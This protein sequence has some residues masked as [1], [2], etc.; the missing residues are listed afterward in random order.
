MSSICII[1][2]YFGKL[3]EYFKFWYRSCLRNKTIN[4]LLITDQL[5]DMVDYNIRII[6]MKID[7]LEKLAQRKLKMEGIWLKKPYKIC[8]FRP[9]FG[10]IFED[11]LEGYDFW[12][13][14]DIDQIFGRIRKFITDDILNEYEKINKNGHL[15]LYKN[16]KR[17]NTLFLKKGSIFSYLD[18]F[19]NKENYAFDEY[20]GIN[21]ISDYQ[22]IKTIYLSDFS[23]IDVIHKR[24]ICKN[25]QNYN[26]QIYSWE[27][28]KLFK[29]Y[30]IN[31][32]LFKEEKMYIHF[33]KKNPLI[34]TRSDYEKLI[35]GS[36]GISKY[37][38]ITPIAIKDNNDYKG[39]LYEKIEI[40]LYI[41]NKV[42]QFVKCNSKQKKI[43]IKQ[44]RR[45]V[46]YENISIWNKQ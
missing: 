27:D 41:I 38:N 12:G 10:V 11:F 33:Q 43:W 39:I 32:K 2:C 14:C 17:I 8:D 29:Y 22:K 42:K 40:V 36:A 30:Y 20:T 19:T 4:F 46:L 3:P 15:T 31:R 6:H 23:D 13:H 9:A 1:A 18:V 7:Q 16:T 26:E 45:K 34:R 5:N 21:M 44:K 37:Q 25:S 24:F 35:I 28:G